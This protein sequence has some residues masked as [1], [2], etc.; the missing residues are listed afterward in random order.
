MSP[1]PA[2]VSDVGHVRQTLAL[3]DTPSPL[4]VCVYAGHSVAP[5]TTK[6]SGRAQV[7][8]TSDMSDTSREA[9]AS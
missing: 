6:R 4:S 9:V 3:L 7:S 2:E 5:R 8:D 1:Q